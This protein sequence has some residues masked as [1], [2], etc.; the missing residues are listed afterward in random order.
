MHNCPAIRAK[1]MRNFLQVIHLKFILVALAAWLLCKWMCLLIEAFIDRRD[2][3]AVYTLADRLRPWTTIKKEELGV[4][5]LTMLGDNRPPPRSPL[6]SS[7]WM[8]LLVLK[9][10]EKISF[11]YNSRSSF[12]F[13]LFST[14]FSCVRVALV[15]VFVGGRGNEC[16]FV[17]SAESLLRVS[18]CLRSVCMGNTESAVWEISAVIISVF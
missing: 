16:V 13:Y 15:R 4:L 5:S 9:V 7:L 12:E 14:V 3:I 11:A 10:P 2:E 6:H 1:L 8:F 18:V 17:C